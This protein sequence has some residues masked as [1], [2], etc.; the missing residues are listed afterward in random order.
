MT[1][2][3]SS[4]MPSTSQRPVARS[5]IRFVWAAVVAATVA[6]G[7]MFYRVADASLGFLAYNEGFYLANG[8]ADASR[9]FFA[10]LVSPLDANNPWVYPV[11][12]ATALRIL[13]STTAVARA[14]S[15]VASMSTIV[16]TFALGKRLYNARIGLVAAVLL[17][18][19]P[20]HM[21]VGRN[22]Q[23]DAL[24]LTLMVAASY[25][26]VRA[27]Q[28]QSRGW[29]LAAGVLLGIGAL[30]KLPV[31]LLIPGFVVW[32]LWRTHDLSWV[33]KPSTWM[34]ATAFAVVLAPWYAYRLLA[35]S[36]FRTAQSQLLGVGGWRG[37][38]Y[39]WHYVLGEMGWMFSP[40]LAVVVV[41]SLVYM[42]AKRQVA[43]KFVISMVSTLF[44]VFIFYNYHSYYF[45]PLAPFGA[46][47][48]A[49]GTDAAAR[50]LSRVG[51]P[52]TERRVAAASATLAGALVLVLLGF[53]A[54]TL[55]A[56]KFV[57]V[58]TDSYV[59]FL[60]EMGYDPSRLVLG[61]DRAIEGL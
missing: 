12:L 28:S 25:A 57:G 56:K 50:R 61:L 1:G 60:A 8:V 52:R 35:S 54:M 2:T 10:P 46:I 19:M 23:I 18:F 53:S 42:A 30:T 9:D 47:A 48:A 49:R 14:V 16:L 26:Y 34:T 45:L 36:T 29:S 38:A 55:S 22:I 6:G 40:V 37:L 32:E 41:A 4:G 43:D 5:G 3:S 51:A 33:R 7:I 21:L 58:P 11:V 27:A 44:A 59:P 20:G 24:M 17:A 39:L 31:L 15:I 13:G